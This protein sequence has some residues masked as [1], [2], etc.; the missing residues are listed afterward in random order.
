MW[1]L[2]LDN[3]EEMVIVKVRKVF[4]VVSEFEEGCIVYKCII[5]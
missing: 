5:I 2:V 4:Y 3:I 1:N